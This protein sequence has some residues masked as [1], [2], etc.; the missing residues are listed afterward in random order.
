[1]NGDA[2]LIHCLNIDDTSKITH[3]NS[4]TIEAIEDRPSL[5]ALEGGKEAFERRENRYGLR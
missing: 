1:M 5:L 2:D 3:S 4:I